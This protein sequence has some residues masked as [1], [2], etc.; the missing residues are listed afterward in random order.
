MLYKLENYFEVMRRDRQTKRRDK[1]RM[2]QNYLKERYHLVLERIQEIQTE[3]TVSNPYRDYFREIGKFIENMA[4]LYQQCE[5][6]K[7]QTLSL[8]QLRDWNRTCYGQ[9]EKEA[10]QTSYANP[11]YAIQQLG[12]EFGQLLSFLTAELYSL[13]SYAVEQQ[14]EAFVIHLELFVELYNVFEQDVVSYKKVRD[15]IY[16]F[17]SDY[18]DVLLPKRMKEIYCPQNSF[19]LSIVTKSNLNDLRYLYFYGESIGYQEEALA[20][21]CIS[22]SKEALEQRGDAIVQ[23]FITSH[24]EEDEK[25]RKDIIAIS[26]QI[27]MESLVYYVIQKLEQEVFIPLIYRHPIHSLYKFE[28]GQKGYDSFLVDEPY[29]NDHESDESIYF[30]KAFLERKTSIIRLALEE[31]KQWIERFAGEIQIDSID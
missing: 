26:Y 11:T 15:V 24:R 22:Y 7:Y 20:K 10:Y 23:Q 3:H 14:L 16:W 28:D 2:T 5:S 6:G 18:C 30:D 12:Q 19:G 29:R 17:E 27:G 8:E 21:K 1:E 13:V 31:Q 25:V 4:E 9:L